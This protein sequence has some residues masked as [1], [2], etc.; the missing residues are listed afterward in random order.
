MFRA[1]NLF[2]NPSSDSTTRLKMKAPL[3]VTLID[4]ELQNAPPVELAITR[5]AIFTTA[6]GHP[7]KRTNAVWHV[8][9]PQEVVEH[10]LEVVEPGSTGLSTP[11]GEREERSNF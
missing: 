5:D 7:S 9:T 4:S 2:I 6:V 8:T 11:V 1:L 10:M 3:S